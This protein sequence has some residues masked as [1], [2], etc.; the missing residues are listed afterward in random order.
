MVCDKKLA[1]V[2]RGILVYTKSFSACFRRTF[3]RT[4]AFRARYCRYDIAKVSKWLLFLFS[5]YDAVEEL[6]QLIMKYK[7][8]TIVLVKQAR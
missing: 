1:S 7:W 6:M 4:G 8:A 5:E 3:T 2:L